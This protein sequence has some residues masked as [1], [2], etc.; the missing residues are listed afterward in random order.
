ML[1]VLSAILEEYWFLM[2][3]VYHHTIPRIVLLP[4]LCHDD[5]AVVG[6]SALLVIFDANRNVMSIT[7]NFGMVI[8]HSPWCTRVQEHRVTQ[9]WSQ[10]HTRDSNC[11][12]INM[13]APG[14]LRLY[15]QMNVQQ[16]PHGHATSPILPRCY[17]NGTG[18]RANRA[19][20]RFLSERR[21]AQSLSSYIATSP[22]SAI[23]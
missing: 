20:L 15:C 12:E 10:N 23:D 4:D 22:A 17:G 6:G 8:E 7:E 1:L 21:H 11:E 19:L 13:F 14:F 18:R 9:H 3:T 5:H 2:I 16:R